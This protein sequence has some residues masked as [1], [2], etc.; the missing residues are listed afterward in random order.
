VKYAKGEAE[1]LAKLGRVDEALRVLEERQLRRER[2]ELLLSSGRQSEAARA[3]AELNDFYMQAQALE[4]TG[5]ASGAR[6]AYDDAKLQLA[7]EWRNTQKPTLDRLEAQLRQAPDGITRERARM[8]WARALGGASVTFERL[9]LVYARTGEAPEKT[10][11]IATNAKT[12]AERHLNALLDA[13]AGAPD[14]Y[15][16]EVA[17]FLALPDRIATLERL[18][19]EYRAGQGGPRPPGTPPRRPG[20]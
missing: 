18:I 6:R 4:A 8:R 11:Q 1:A 9:A 7:E 13:E 2:A 12:F 19:G 15:G 16:Q 20:R 17:R 5:D 3:F 10:A 14:P